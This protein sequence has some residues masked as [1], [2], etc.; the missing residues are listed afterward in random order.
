MSGTTSNAPE[1]IRGA[2]AIEKAVIASL[3]GIGLTVRAE[4]F[5]WNNGRP[6]VPPPEAFVM[7]VKPDGAPS[8]EVTFSR[9]QLEDSADR[10]RDDVRAT[11]EAISRRYV[12]LRSAK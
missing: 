7:K 10:V 12:Q 3:K 11:V 8:N 6:L 4:H 5:E 9:E 2:Q 1:V